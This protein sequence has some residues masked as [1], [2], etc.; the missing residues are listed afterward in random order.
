[1]EKSKVAKRKIKCQGGRLRF[2]IE[3][4]W[5]EPPNR[6]HLSVELKEVGEED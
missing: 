3:N 4:G 2:S 5:G 1:M 6:C